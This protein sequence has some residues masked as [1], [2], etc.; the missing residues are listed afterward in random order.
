LRQKAPLGVLDFI[1]FQQ[2]QLPKSFQLAL[3]GTD[4]SVLAFQMLSAVPTSKTSSQIASEG[5]V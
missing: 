1:F 2:F 4:F 5:T 3:E